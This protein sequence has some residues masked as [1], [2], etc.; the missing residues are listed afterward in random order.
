MSTQDTAI[1]V[2]E[3]TPGWRAV[4][5]NELYRYRDLLR[6]LTLRSI[7]A[8]YAQSA[9]GIGW[10][11]IQP[12]FTMIIFTVVFGRFAKLDSHG[13]PYSLFSL[14]A[15]VPWTYFS[16]ALLNASNSLVNQS[17]LLSKVYFPR[18]ILPLS[19]VTA[20]L[21]DLCIAMVMLFVL[22]AIYQIVPTWNCIFLPVLLII[23]IA[24]ALGIGLWLTS[25]AIQYRDIRHALTFVVQ[26]GM[27]SSP[28]IYSA[29]IIPSS[30]RYFYAI[31]PMVGVIEGFRSA[32][33]STG[34]MP[35]DLIGIGAFSATFFL[36]TGLLYFRR[37]ERVFSD[38]A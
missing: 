32:L 1:Q 19:D 10:A 27:Y 6:F 34:P 36:A 4:D 18:L 33:L 9:I 16:S 15:L 13:V 17:H 28:V 3:P 20:K 38:V 26:L 2:I 12:L 5:F 22:M 21:V 14:A 24:S 37:Q 11:V 7:K 23:M 25:L 30:F 31:N 35:W 29:S 8:L